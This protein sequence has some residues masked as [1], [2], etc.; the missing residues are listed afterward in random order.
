MNGRRRQQLEDINVALSEILDNIYRAKTDVE[1][2]KDDEEISK[3]NIPES[4]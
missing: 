4:L 2:V 1:T 3:D